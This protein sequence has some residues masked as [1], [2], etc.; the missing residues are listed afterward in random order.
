MSCVM[1]VVRLNLKGWDCCAVVV[2]CTYLSRCH[3]PHLNRLQHHNMWHCFEWK[4]INF[5]RLL[6]L[7][8]TDVWKWNSDMSI[9]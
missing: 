4:S 6:G 9:V 2:G 3:F 1:F 5:W 8:T 7:T